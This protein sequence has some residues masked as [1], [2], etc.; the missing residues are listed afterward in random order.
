MEGMLRADD[1]LAGDEE[2]VVRDGGSAEAEL[3][4]LIGDELRRLAAAHLAQLRPGQTLQPTALIHEAWILLAGGA[5]LGWDSRRQFF[6]TAARTMREIIVDHVRRNAGRDVD[7]ALA[8]RGFPAGDALTIDA[9]LTALDIDHPRKAQ[10]VIM[11]YFA[12]FSV[13]EIAAMLGLTTRT[14]EREWR[15]ARGFLRAALSREPV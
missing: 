7:F 10:V 13:P 11:R 3:L 1:V 12:G 8:R 9:A 14:V 2:A 15:F 5:A 6:G 4:P